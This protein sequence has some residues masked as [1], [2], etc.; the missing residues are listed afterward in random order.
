MIIEMTTGEMHL[1]SSAVLAEGAISRW[2]EW[3]TA[4]IS[5]RYHFLGN[6]GG[7][8]TANSNQYQVTFKGRVNFDKSGRYNLEAGLFSGNSFTGGCNRSG[9]GSAKGQS[10]L[11]LKQLFF[12][13]RPVSGVEIQYGG[14][15]FRSWAIY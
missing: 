4:S 7:A 15:Y 6:L 2:F 9:W 8:T 13:I 1:T 11:F 10:N 12:S 3:E 14:L 5:S